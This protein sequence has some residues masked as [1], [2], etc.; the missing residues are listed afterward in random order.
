[1]V[2]KRFIILAA[3]MISLIP[4]MVFAA[5]DGNIRVL[6]SILFV[7][8]DGD[9]LQDEMER[10][11]YKTD[12]LDDDSDNDGYSDGAEVRYEGNPLNPD[13]S[14]LKGELQVTSVQ[15]GAEVF[16]D[17]NFGYLGKFAGLTSSDT[18][19][20]IRDISL[21][22]H[23]LRL[24]YPGYEDSYDVINVLPPKKL[25][26]VTVAQPSLVPL[27]LPDYGNA[28]RLMSGILP[29]DAGDSAVPVVVDWDNDGK[30]DVIAGNSSGELLFYKNRGSD[31][32]PD[33]SE[34]IPVIGSDNFLAPFVVDWD[35]D[36]KKDILTGTQDGAVLV[37]RNTGSDSAPSFDDGGISVV[38]LTGGYARPFV[39]DWDGDRKKDLVTGDGSGKINVFLNTGTDDKPL[40]DATPFTVLSLGTG[41]VSPFVVTDWD[42]D[43]GMDIIAG[44]SDGL[45]ML[46]PVP[47]KA[48]NNNVQR[49]I[50][51]GYNA[52]PFVVD[53]NG[54]GIK[55]LLI[56]NGDGEILYY[57]NH[58]PVASFAVP[59]MI[60]EGGDVLMDGGASFDPD[61]DLLS[62]YWDFGDGVVVADKGL[63]AHYT[64]PDDG[65]YPVTLTVKDSYGDSHSIR[66]DIH[67]INT[68]PIAYA[69][70][71]Q[72]VI[73]GDS[74]YFSGD[75]TDHGIKDTHFIAW[76]FGDGTAITSELSPVHTF[77]TA[78]LYTVTLTITDNAGEYSHDQI[79]VKADEAG[80][81][82]PISLSYPYGGIV[83]SASYV[84]LNGI[85]NIPG[86]A[87]VVMINDR[88]VRMN[89]DRSFTD[90]IDL[91][92]GSNT[93]S[94]S[95]TDQDGYTYTERMKI[96]R[97]GGDITGDGIVGIEDALKVLSISSGMESPESLGLDPA[98]IDVAPLLKDNSEN[99]AENPD[100]SVI[101]APDGVI[102]VADS[103]IL[104]RAALG[105]II[106]PVL[107]RP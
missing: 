45:V 89:S 74:V 69:G 68:A 30:K 8:S 56:G 76:D 29:L 70:S 44:T 75:Y 22:M 49:D 104:L 52:S 77:N 99:I 4:C 35:N 90:K 96:N 65:V 28:V 67:V 32:S 92:P 107:P 23:I 16:L 46:G 37:F 66:K 58:T 93:V 20:V 85:L 61:M 47:L 11:V 17:G 88:Q 15:A 54:D 34:G 94:I 18:A 81:I 95:V 103:L 101:P 79:L 9:G 71:D 41:S 57:G 82:R 64:F 27:V 38:T 87:V 12:P 6:V 72:R 102:N 50:D 42:G 97:S 98:V 60:K 39:V 53:W 55:D 3:L 19:L 73:A 33:L 10:E 86:D 14:P 91:A 7:D 5:D 106:L 100:G 24:S 43:A 63:S 80:T 13:I 1:M 25:D 84:D 31:T 59:D 78:G 36:R 2:Q 26:D 51:A 21:G 48:A 62:Y 105:D 40:F 83:Y